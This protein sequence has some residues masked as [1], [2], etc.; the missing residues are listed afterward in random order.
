MTQFMEINSL[1]QEAL[2]KNRKWF[3]AAG[4]A[5]I[6]IGL[7]AV[8]L[9]TL[10]TLISVILLG[11][12]VFVGGVVSLINS[13]KFWRWQRSGFYF[14]LLVSLLYLIVG[15]LLMF[16]PVAAAASLTMLLAIFFLLLG[17]F[18]L[19]S[20]FMTRLP[21]WGWNAFSGVLSIILA[22]LIFMHWPAT[23]LFVIGLFI[24]IDLIF[25]GW[26]YVMLALSAKA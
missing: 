2:R 21:N 24:G 16:N 13:F 19:W 15:A 14:H 3:L 20:A 12:L 4:I 8:S 10:T 23:S 1:V 17:I 5:L 18:R 26:F 25:A 22:V 11:V 7:V 9:A 6:L